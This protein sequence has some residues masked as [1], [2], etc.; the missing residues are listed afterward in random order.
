MPKK[1]KI[2]PYRGAGW[3]TGRKTK[4]AAKKAGGRIYFYNNKELL[5]YD[6][7]KQDQLKTSFN[8]F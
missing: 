4:G 7:G 1:T 2:R 5:F 8:L 3:K 6:F